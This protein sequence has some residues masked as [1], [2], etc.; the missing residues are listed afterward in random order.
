MKD[1]GKGK[2]WNNRFTSRFGNISTSGS[3]I[4]KEFR[5]EFVN[6]IIFK[7]SSGSTEFGD[8]IDD[9]HNFTGSIEV[10]GTLNIPTGSIDVRRWYRWFKH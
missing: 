5:T 3:I 2:S 6:Q 10:S 1:V 7:T 4:L 8:S 9:V